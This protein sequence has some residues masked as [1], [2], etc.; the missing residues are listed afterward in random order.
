MVVDTS[1]R[2]R[3]ILTTK[4]RKMRARTMTISRV[5]TRSYVKVCQAV[6]MVKYC[7]DGDQPE[8]SS[9]PRL[10]QKLRSY[11]PRTG[12]ANLQMEPREDQRSRTILVR[13]PVLPPIDPPQTPS[14]KTTSWLP[15]YLPSPSPVPSHPENASHRLICPPPNQ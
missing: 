6:Q 10:K 2:G 11:Q 12:T 8:K 5:K 4:M 1:T 7:A 13:K 15:C 9:E 14:P 3:A